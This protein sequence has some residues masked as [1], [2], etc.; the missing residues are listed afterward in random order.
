MGS[1]YAA[2]LRSGKLQ[3]DAGQWG[4]R[5]H[6]RRESTPLL[7][8]WHTTSSWSGRTRESTTNKGVRSTT[9]PRSSRCVPSL[10]YSISA[11]YSRECHLNSRTCK[12]C[13]TSDHLLSLLTT[14]SLDPVPSLPPALPPPPPQ[15]RTTAPE[16]TR[17]LSSL[18]PPSVPLP[19]PLQR[20]GSPSS[21]LN[22]IRH[23][24]SL[25]SLS[26]SKL[27]P[28][29]QS[30]QKRQDRILLFFYTLRR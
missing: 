26:S 3:A 18:P 24:R 11:S 30:K 10:P 14:P 6:S 15:R 9:I 2:T 27:P 19:P 25:L 1:W 23:L 17:R 12:S 7:Q 20:N 4:N 16:S 5:T 29:L 8:R 21:L 28:Q 22:L 13:G